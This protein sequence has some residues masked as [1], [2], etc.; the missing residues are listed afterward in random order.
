MPLRYTRKSDTPNYGVQRIVGLPAVKTAFWIS[1]GFIAYVYAVY[2]IAI[3]AA[4][5]LRPWA[6]RTPP[7][8]PSETQRVLVSVCIAARN[9]AARLPRKIDNLQ[10][11]NYPQELIEI[12]IASD[13]STDD[14]LQVLSDD[15]RAHVLDCASKGKAAAVNCAVA[16]AQGSIVVLTDVRQ[17]LS[18]GAIAALVERLQCDPTVGIVS[19]ELVHLKPGSQVESSIGLYWR[20]EKWIRRCESAYFSTVG[21][22]GAL[23]AMHRDDFVPLRD[24]TLLDDFDEPMSVIRTGK[25]VIL[26]DQAKAYDRLETNI[27]AERRRKI[28]TLAGNWQS[29]C[30]N[31]W[32]LDPWSNPVWW[33]YLSH[34]LG[35]LL[36]P[37]ALISLLASSSVV[38]DRTYNGFAVVQ[39]LFWACALGG[40]LCPTIQRFRPI[41]L[42]SVFLQ[43]NLAAVLGLA[44]F[45]LRRT[46]AVWDR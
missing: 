30:R 7:P 35:R 5:R 9:E 3:W 46:D 26:D 27:A 36:V 4:S 32:L 18:E 43:L 6:S 20:Y 2:P 38:T 22:T 24:G 10:S 41:G 29:L 21:A 19:G 34:K 37:F 28:R 13:S 23:Y 42:A 16:A 8:D 1:F 33:Q 15:G 39:G 25:R 45:S 31:L 12:I 40:T 11:Q 14:T 44:Y 17:Q